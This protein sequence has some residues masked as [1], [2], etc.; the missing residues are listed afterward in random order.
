MSR[1]PMTYEEAIRAGGVLVEEDKP[2]T[3]EEAIRL[4]GVDVDE[5]G[6][7]KPSLIERG[8]GLAKG[9]GERWRIAEEKRGK[10][11]REGIARLRPV[12]EETPGVEP[13]PRYE[14]YR[15][16]ISPPEGISEEQNKFYL[17][18]LDE[19]LTDPN[20]KG[21]EQKYVDYLTRI[22]Y[23]DNEANF[24]K[25]YAD[26]VAF[27]ESKGQK[28]SPDP[29]A[30]EHEYDY[31]KAYEQ[32]LTPQL[33]EHGDYR[34]PDIGKPP[35][36]LAR[37][38]G[39]KAFPDKMMEAYPLGE[40]MV[41]EPWEP[42]LK[43]QA[44]SESPI[45]DVPMAMAPP[46]LQDLPWGSRE[47]FVKGEIEQPAKNILRGAKE[48]SR[49]FWHNVANIPMVIGKGISAGTVS[50]DVT[51]LDR[52]ATILSEKT[53]EK[54]PHALQK[55]EDF[56]RG[57]ADL[58]AEAEPGLEVVDQFPDS[59]TL[60]DKLYQAI[61]QTPGVIGEYAVGSR[62]FGNVA[63]MAFVDA[64]KEA[65]KEPLDVLI[66]AVR[67]ATL[68]RALEGTHALKR[69][70]RA[71]A[72]ASLFGVPAAVETGDTKETAVAALTGAGLGAFGK[73]GHMDTRDVI[74]AG[75][76]GIA[77]RNVER[78]IEAIQTARAV[79][80]M[81]RK[82]RE[83]KEKP[84]EAEAKP[85]EGIPT[86]KP[87]PSKPEKPTPE[88]KPTVPV[89]AVNE[90][91]IATIPEAE[92][93]LA[94]AK[95]RFDMV[96]GEYNAADAAGKRDLIDDW[97]RAQKS[98]IA[99]EDRIA[100][101]KKGIPPAEQPK[102]PEE[103][104][105]APAKPEAG[106]ALPPVGEF[107]S[108]VKKNQET[109]RQS[110]NVTQPGVKALYDAA[111]GYHREM[112]L[113]AIEGKT[114]IPWKVADDYF[115]WSKEDGWEYHN[116]GG[117][118]M[119]VSKENARFLS[120]SYPEISGKP[121]EPAKPEAPTVGAPVE[122]PTGK[123]G[124]EPGK[125]VVP[126]LP[127]GE[128]PP[129]TPSLE[130][131]FLIEGKGYKNWREFLD[132]DAYISDEHMG[133]KLYLSRPGGLTVIV[134]PDKSVMAG[135]PSVMEQAWGQFKE[136]PGMEL[137]R[138]LWRE[139][140]EGVSPPQTPV[141]ETVAEAVDA[142][143]Y[144][145]L[146]N[147]E[148][149]K[150]LLENI[151]QA[152]K[153]QK[154]GI[155]KGEMVEIHIPR[156]GDFKV[157]NNPEALKRY[158]DAVQKLF[159]TKSETG[160]LKPAGKVAAVSKGEKRPTGTIGAVTV[161]GDYVTD[162]HFALRAKKSQFKI[163]PSQ[164]DADVF[165]DRGR[166]ITPEEVQK[167]I[168]KAK[169]IEL[170]SKEEFLYRETDFLGGGEQ[171]ALGIADFPIALTG[172]DAINVVRLIDRKGNEAYIDQDYYSAVKNVYPDAEF[173][174]SKKEP[175]NSAVAVLLPKEKEPIG[176][177]MP[178][179]PD[180]LGQLIKE[181]REGKFPEIPKERVE[182][183]KK[184]AEEAEEV[185]EEEYPEEV[186]EEEY[187]PEEEIV[188]EAE[189]WQK[190]MKDYVEGEIENLRQTKAWKEAP[191]SYI[192]T[193]EES[194]K[195]KAEDRWLEATE[196][197]F[198]EGKDVPAENRPSWALTAK[199]WANRSGD[200]L[201]QSI[202]DSH[203][204]MVKEAAKEGKPVPQKVIDDVYGKEE[205]GTDLDVIQNE[206]D[207]MGDRK[208]ILKTKLR[209]RYDV[210]QDLEKRLK[211]N[212]KLTAEDAI[213]DYL[214]EVNKNE[215]LSLINK[216]NKRKAAIAVRDS[217][218]ALRK[219]AQ[220][221]AEG[222]AEEEVLESRGPRLRPE[223][224][225]KRTK[226]DVRETEVPTDEIYAGV[227]K[228][229][230]IIKLFQEKFDIP[231]RVGRMPKIKGLLGQYKVKI[232]AI[233]LK[234]ANDIATAAHEIG[235]ALNK[236]LWPTKGLNL[237]IRAFAPFADELRPLATMGHPMK[238]GFA[239]FL[240]KY[241]VDEA[242]AKAKAPKFYAF[243]EEALAEKAP[244]VREILLEARKMYK[245]YE[246]QGPEAHFL[247]MMDYE[248]EGRIGVTFSKIYTHFVH[249]LYPMEK[250]VMEMAEGGKLP[251]DMDPHVLMRL[252]AGNEGRADVFMNY[253][254]FKFGTYEFYGKS[255]R[256]IL[257]PVKDDVVLL[258]VYLMAKN[259]IRWNKKG[260]ETGFDMGH[261]R[262]IVEKYDSRFRKTHNE[263]INFQ[264]AGL[265]YMLDAGVIDVKGYLRMRK[266]HRDYIPFFRVA[267][268]LNGKRGFK[269]GKGYEIQRSPLKYAFGGAGDYIPP[270][271]SI[272]KNT[273]LYINSAERNA[274]G[275]ALVKL[276]QSKHGLGKYVEKIPADKRVAAAMGETELRSI[277]AKYGKWVETE[278]YR[279]LH[280]TVRESIRDEAAGD[281]AQTMDSKIE[282][283]LLEALT[284]RGWSPAEAQQIIDRIKK[285]PAGESRNRV[286]ERELT[287]T[288]VL[289]KTR[290]MGIDMPEGPHLLWRDS[291]YKPA[292]NVI[293]VMEKG[294][295]EFYEVH[296]DIYRTFMALDKES[297]STLMRIMGAPTR[298]LRAGATLSFEFM[299]RNPIRDQI[300]AYVF[301]KY[302]Y[303]P[304]IDWFRGIYS[305]LK[306]DEYYQMWKMS[307]AEQAALVSMDR[308]KHMTTLEDILRD[309]RLKKLSGWKEASK[310]AI[311]HP[312]DAL[313]A[314][315]E[316]GEEGTRV[317]E[318]RKGLKAEGRTKAGIQ[319]AG[320]ASRDVSLDFR[321][322]GITGRSM[323][324]LIAFW[325][326]NVQ[327]IDKT[328]RELRDNPTVVL[329]RIFASITLPSVLLAIANQDDKEIRRLPAW[330]KWVF[331]HIRA[332]KHILRLPKAPVLG[333]IFG[334]IPQT[335]VWSTMDNKKADYEEM[336]SEILKAV[337]PGWMPT[338]LSPF[339]EAIAGK[340]LFLD[341]P[342]VPAGKR[343]VRNGYQYTPYTT[344]VAKKLGELMDGIP[345]VG[346]S[347]L[348]NPIMVEN[349]I[350]SWTGNLGKL[351]LQTAD[352]S[353]KLA[354]VFGDLPP[355]PTKTWSDIPLVRGFVSRY[356]SYGMEPINKFY[357]DYNSA[358]ETLATVK[359]LVKEGRIKPA[360]K[361]LVAS[362]IVKIETVKKAI[363]TQR[364]VIQLIRYNPNMDPD[365]KKELID[366]LL[367][368]MAISAER[369]NE[370]LDKVKARLKAVGK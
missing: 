89:P 117:I 200:T 181:T 287:N 67:G 307:G 39:I 302:G 52:A 147:P 159:P 209:N 219:E 316:I 370:L 224:G 29:Y 195:R 192:R 1:K 172:K 321:R 334:T 336:T 228:R 353:L 330:E 352:E 189:P 317:G 274:I 49:A 42:E 169:D 180:T 204:K 103:K 256:E 157:Y 126:G 72:M 53:G 68:G 194:E 210:L 162:G 291:P 363:S 323:N 288:V 257:D 333:T 91:E 149:K 230:D 30:P 329:P 232:E 252:F 358:Q 319:K 150:Y 71:G 78:K 227:T 85:K 140:P 69:L 213:I 366:K 19:K 237:S 247:S 310:Y 6:T 18:W 94:A 161:A 99:I 205:Y 86:E 3:Y 314:L 38:A 267:D 61:G 36:R 185:P 368:S 35:E 158:R 283:K 168:P 197:A 215:Y 146:T 251:P 118:W 107:L 278:E 16:D 56:I 28:L 79:Q 175:G 320:L 304:G 191:N 263:I 357:E 261:A 166:T 173:G 165:A 326:A 341:R 223:P 351:I 285:A 50:G 128:A 308:Q 109:F 152:I 369:G 171:E 142:S 335:I 262:A 108:T 290:T 196:N 176:A 80:E 33:T 347:M 129:Q 212:P 73:P 236:H 360:K 148:M 272:I 98:I 313:R 253:R 193:L 66:G 281:T 9:Y 216:S 37:E 295:A 183:A 88:P 325:N 14:G 244:E 82:I 120:E 96:A 75:L 121:V 64:L 343:G 282:S 20:L 306:R 214:A 258:E 133:H 76:E 90:S 31:K 312:L 206:L 25:W 141:S 269:K 299:A 4:G 179:D 364:E 84:K 44:P 122:A 41:G 8:L 264:K 97:E 266:A 62:L 284:A 40:A 238:E 280:Q 246:K 339:V 226:E 367:I 144:G 233:R 24:R 136:M 102:A 305:V 77:R 243:F 311:K 132:K 300:T 186:P 322:I 355:E 190:S 229:S 156:D 187:P 81:E 231:I 43:P 15:L 105:K 365:K 5:E 225:F 170:V 17:G 145:G 208:K 46:S 54:Q 100:E 60:I 270:L 45:G 101:L 164:R 337:S 218:P 174:L 163:R 340:S 259:A 201:D 324:Q 293:A 345:I 127:E 241:V 115:R 63:G 356:P 26:Q 32:R 298:V 286:I 23:R 297:V 289:Q 248:G 135:N 138:G 123:P 57:F 47:E 153:D 294:K 271:E 362:D 125:G 338:G 273:H 104:P 220:E 255:L 275:R 155:S 160:K 254:P 349:L 131:D 12:P 55:V 137:N 332:G 95:K 279:T 58:A 292:G 22:G 361:M 328:F 309:T 301:S 327:G 65:G 106:W 93:A 177:I 154:M 342:L 350:Q 276:S 167:V 70:P 331:Y 359:A 245:L 235:H 354:G 11:F 2:L 139:R 143:D 207:K 34:W 260:L 51:I 234:L 211:E 151:D 83:S 110:L 203:R 7:K 315:S 249:D 59:D 21:Q 119:T 250:V 198:I 303:K 277:L 182:E 112:V 239:E 74:R 134:G 348:A 114:E 130:N 92:A 296:P 48:S 188:G 202:I 27:L 217:L 268:Y 346:D 265:R 13:K 222:E 318:F 178:L 111:R 242:D 124:I 113:R 10:E 221:F 87:K 344:E 240:S 116:A 184:R 199:E